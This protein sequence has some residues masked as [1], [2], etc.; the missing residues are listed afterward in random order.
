M[1][2]EQANRPALV[3]WSAL[4]IDCPEP[5][6]MAE[7]Y[8]TLLDGKITRRTADSAYV[9]AAGVL[10]VFRAVPDCR[11]PTWP[12]PEVPLHSHFELRWSH[13]Q[14]VEGDRVEPAGEVALESSRDRRPKAGRF[15][16]ERDAPSPCPAPHPA[17]AADARP[18][19]RLS[20]NRHTAAVRHPHAR[21]APGGACR[22]RVEEIIRGYP[23]RGPSC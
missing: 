3:E 1:T 11:P 16:I 12:S 18:P 9:A 23:A 13:A 19:G 2:E 22:R 5:N 21:S 10:L 6:V 15:R 17:G 4:T 7:F 20:R 8:A 14:A